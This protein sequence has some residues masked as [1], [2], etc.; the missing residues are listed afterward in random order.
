[1]NWD[2]PASLRMRF[3]V[4]IQATNII[5]QHRHLVKYPS[6]IHPNSTQLILTHF[7]ETINL[8]NIYFYNKNL[9]YH[10]CFK[11]QNS[12]GWTVNRHYLWF[13]YLT[14]WLWSR[15]SLNQLNHEPKVI[16]CQLSV[17]KALIMVTTFLCLIIPIL[18]E[19]S[20]IIWSLPTR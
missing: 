6:M 14:L 9:S 7:L 20:L 13:S 16:Q 5:Y 15:P 1:L 12:T 10:Q 3:R 18:R 8:K 4:Q 2:A 19:R 17:F 11:I